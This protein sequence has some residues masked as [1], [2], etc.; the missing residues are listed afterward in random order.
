MAVEWGVYEGHEAVGID[1][2][3]SPATVTKD[4]ATVTLTW[5]VYVRTDGWTIYS[6]NQTLTVSGAVAA[7]TDFEFGTTATPATPAGS[8]RLVGTWTQTVTPSYSAT[9]TQTITAA[10]SGMFNGGTP[11]HSRSFV[12]PKRPPQAPSPAAAAAAAYVSDARIDVSWTR[13]A[14]AASTGTIWTNVDVWRATDGGSYV[15]VAS[16]TGTATSWADATTAANKTYRYAVRGRNVSGS[17]AWAYT[18][19]VDTTPAAPTG[20]AAVKSGAAI[21]VTW[22]SNSPGAALFEVRDGT[23]VL[24]TATGSTYTHT[25]PSTSITHTYTVRA[26]AQDGGTR[27]SAW[28][29]PSNTVQ[30]LAAPLAPTGLT[31]NGAVQDAAANIV[32]AWTHNPVDTTAQRLKDVRYRLDGGAWVN[33]GQQTSTVSTWT[34]TPGNVAGASTVEWQVRTAGEHADFSPWSATASVP[35]SLRPTVAINTPAN[36]A[37][38]TTPFLTVAW[39]YSQPSGHAQSAWRARLLDSTGAVIAQA[40]GTGTTTTWSPTGPVLDDGQSYTVEVAV[41]ESSGLESTPDTAAITVAFPAPLPPTIVTDWDVDGGYLTV[42]VQPDAGPSNPDPITYSVDRSWNG[43]PWETLGTDLDITGDLIDWTVPLTGITTYRITA[44]SAL[45]SAVTVE[46]AITVNA[47]PCDVYLS[48]G[49]GMAYCVRLT[50]H[51]Q[52]SIRT[53]RDRTLNQ[54]AGRAAPV[55]TTGTTVPTS[56]SLSANI[57]PQR[58]GTRTV[59]IEDVETLCALPG[60]HL[61]RDHEGRNWWVSLS[62]VQIGLDYIAPIS[63]TLTRVDGGTLEQRNATAR[64]AAPAIREISPGL[65]TIVGGTTTDVAPGTYTWTP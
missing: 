2:T 15:S 6:D 63:L 52:R 61:Y 13:P 65:Y 33:P 38:L 25:A 44:L 45:P 35:L 40:A 19:N 36:G 54:Y 29:A 64:H 57:F 47:E 50:R 22:T 26:V 59:T 20:V 16:L 1:V 14:N 10:V 41:T 51:I 62:D 32:L 39:G 9:S 24:G 58:E 49:P 37:T 31:P 56:M 7:S 21:T 11:S 28:S 12:V 42:T 48:G 18:G 3:M 5:R 17:S 30:L 4:T 27:Y 34:L 8:A 43:G 55:E 23:T 53:G 60:P 46:H